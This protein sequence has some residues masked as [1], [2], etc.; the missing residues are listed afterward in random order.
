MRIIGGK[1]RG[2][3][4]WSPEGKEVRPTSDRARESVFNILYSK[5]GGNY[6]ETRLLDVFAGTGALG[7][8]A[9]SRGCSHVTFVDI[10]TSLVA[11]NAKLF[12]QESGKI[13]ILK[14]NAAMLPKAV[15]KYNL[16]FMDAPYAK[17]LSQQALQELAAKN[18]LD[19]RA[20][21]IVEIRKDECW[22]LPTAYELLDER[23]YG[24]A[25][26]LFLRKM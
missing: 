7:F 4:L 26:L 23:V 14:A 1:Y 19:D 10:D 21:C 6:A 20:V 5:L 24:L 13:S 2:K 11:K 25:R 3:K 12:P 9:I 17:G 18:W 15:R 22:E 16:V 8:E